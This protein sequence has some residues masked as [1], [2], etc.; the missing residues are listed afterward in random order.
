MTHLALPV[1]GFLGFPTFTHSTLHARIPIATFDLQT[2]FVSDHFSS[3]AVPL[4]STVSSFLLLPRLSLGLFYPRRQLG[5]SKI[6]P[7]ITSAWCWGQIRGGG[8]S[9]KSAKIERMTGRGDGK[10]KASPFL[11]RFN[12]GKWTSEMADSINCPLNGGQFH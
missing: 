5:M 8:G 9:F 11:M 7:G 3:F 1:G 2:W 12:L 6:H 4:L 10:W